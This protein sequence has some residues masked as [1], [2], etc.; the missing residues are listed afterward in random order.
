MKRAA[1]L[2]FALVLLGIGVY[3]LFFRSPSQNAAPASESTS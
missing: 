1:P 3:L 2:L